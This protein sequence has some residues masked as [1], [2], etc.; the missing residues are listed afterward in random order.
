MN[1][2]SFLILFSHFMQKLGPANT[3][4][5]VVRDVKKVQEKNP[6]TI[7]YL[8]FQIFSLCND[9]IVFLLCRGTSLLT[10]R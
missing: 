3:L 4:N 5:A 6:K 1:P 10:I 9:N 8:T 2:S 7:R